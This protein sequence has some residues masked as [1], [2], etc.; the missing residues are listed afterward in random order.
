M[1]VLNDLEL[2][3]SSKKQEKWAKS[4]GGYLYLGSGRANKNK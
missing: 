2:I 3:R 1:R 4:R